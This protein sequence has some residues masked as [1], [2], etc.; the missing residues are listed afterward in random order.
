VSS[1]FFVHP[2]LAGFEHGIE[3]RE[4]FS[5]AGRYS[6]L[7]ELTGGNEPGIKAAQNRIATNSRNRR[8]VQRISMIPQ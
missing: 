8:R 4:Q 6:D 1:N 7:E 2:N 5:H 3:D